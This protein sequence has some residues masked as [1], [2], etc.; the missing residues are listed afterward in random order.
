MPLG[1]KKWEERP[2]DRPAKGE[3]GYFLPAE[4]PGQPPPQPQE[5]PPLRLMTLLT[6]SARQHTSTQ[7][8][9][10]VAI[11]INPFQDMSIIVPCTA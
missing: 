10:A 9:I 11:W 6:A 5:H 3:A 8:T 1:L 4:Q 7:N 2:G